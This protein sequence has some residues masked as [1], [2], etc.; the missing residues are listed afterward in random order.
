MCHAAVFSSIVQYWP[1][2]LGFL[3]QRQSPHELVMDLVGVVKRSIGTIG[4]ASIAPTMLERFEGL[5][6]VDSIAITSPTAVGE[7][8]SAGVAVVVLSTGHRLDQSDMFWSV[9]L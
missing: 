7:E 1:P 2:G 6:V 3:V 8:V 5:K 4:L 9:S